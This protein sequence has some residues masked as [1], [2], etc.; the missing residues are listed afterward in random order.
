MG[1][2]LGPLKAKNLRQTT[3][4][5]KKKNELLIFK[6]DKCITS[7][8][9]HLETK[10]KKMTPKNGANLLKRFS[11][12]ATFTGW[13]YMCTFFKCSSLLLTRKIEICYI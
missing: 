8:K 6:I 10:S 3:T 1:I 13:I 4:D 7:E 9:K 12:V 2:F 5:G 11:H